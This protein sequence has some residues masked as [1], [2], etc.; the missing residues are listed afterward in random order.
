[1]KFD[2]QV[3]DPMGR[4]IDGCVE[5]TSGEAAAHI[6]R[7]DG[8]IIQKIEESDDSEGFFSKHC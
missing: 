5:A 2:Y 7:R 6:L 4:E 3:T 1:M 8:F